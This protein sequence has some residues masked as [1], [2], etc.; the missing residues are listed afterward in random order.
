MKQ[1]GNEKIKKLNK[2]IKML[3]DEIK[4]KELLI[5]KAQTDREQIQDFCVYYQYGSTPKEIPF[6][7]VLNTG[8]VTVWL[9]KTGPYQANVF[10]KVNRQIDLDVSYGEIQNLQN[11]WKRIMDEISSTL[12]KTF[13]VNK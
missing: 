7:P 8:E 2:Q 3:K 6:R 10:F 12:D 4:A 5:I 11:I 9:E 1:A 13:P